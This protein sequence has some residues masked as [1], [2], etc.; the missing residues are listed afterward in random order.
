[1]SERG[2]LDMKRIATFLTVIALTVSV[3]GCSF[4]HGKAPEFESMEID[5]EAADRG[6]VIPF[7]TGFVENRWF[8]E[9]N[10]A[11]LSFITLDGEVIC[12]DPFDDVYS[13]DDEGVYIVRRTV[14]GV[15]KYGFLSY[16]SA[17]FTGLVYDGAAKAEGS[18]KDGVCFYGTN[19]ADGKLWI[20][21]L[22]NNLNVISTKAVTIDEEEISMD[23]ANAQLSV[24]YTDAKSTVMIN[25]NE[26][27]YKIMLIDNASGRLLFEGN[28]GN[29]LRTI[30]IFGNV[31]ID[32]NTLHDALTVYD[33]SGKK[34]IDDI[35]AYIGLLSDDRFLVAGDNRIDIYD[36]GWKVIDSMDIPDG[37]TVMT[38]FGR[39]AVADGSQTLVYDKELN[40]IN[41]LDYSADTGAYFRDWHNY[42]EGDMYY[43]TITGIGKIINFNTG[44]QIIKEDNFSYEFEKGY[45]IANNHNYGYIET[46]MWRI[47]DKDLNLLQKGEGM[48]DVIR[49]EVTGDLYMIVDNDSLV[50]V[51]S[52]PDFRELFSFEGNSHRLEATD[53]RFYWWDLDYFVLMDGS[54]EELCR[55][56]VDYGESWNK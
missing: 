53:G 3:V 35:S 56:D 7:V 4:N 12:S 25:R 9:N 47:Y 49:D 18:K 30:F 20:S 43:D 15:S 32:A 46:Y 28:G 36:T 33:M 1:M 8:K 54:G 51:Y 14:D 52:L 48:V 27:Y 29:G 24:L 13:Y 23:A 17:L 31:I 45:I 10:I 16:D 41:T 44:A 50:T 2:Y 22:D 5:L 19:Y 38:S 11:Y 26:F 34:L 6:R 55:L 39:I 42:G 40:L 21:S 37:S